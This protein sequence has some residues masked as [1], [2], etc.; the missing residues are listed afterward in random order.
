MNWRNSNPDNIPIPPSIENNTTELSPTMRKVRDRINEM[1]AHRSNIGIE[2]NTVMEALYD[3]SKDWSFWTSH[4]YD[5]LIFARA[6]DAA[7]G[8]NNM[9]EINELETYF[10]FALA[11]GE[12]EIVRTI[13][14]RIRK[15]WNSAA[16]DFKTRLASARAAV[17]KGGNIHKEELDRIEADFALWEEE[18]QQTQPK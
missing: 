10:P 6:A 8:N 7:T 18:E 9:K 12:L 14:N 1:F 17:A 13:M 3:V 4:F 5:A 15:Y 16:W 11:L 2:I